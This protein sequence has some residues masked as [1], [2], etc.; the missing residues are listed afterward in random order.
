MNK[1]MIAVFF[2]LI[3]I[4]TAYALIRV[5]NESGTDIWLYFRTNRQDNRSYMVWVRQHGFISLPL[6]TF[7]VAATLADPNQKTEDI[8][9][10]GPAADEIPTIADSVSE[11]KVTVTSKAQ[12]FQRT[13]AYELI[14]PNAKELEAQYVKEHQAKVK[15][16]I[17]EAVAQ[18]PSGVA[19]IAAEYCSPEEEP[20][21]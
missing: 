19:G 14:I 2:A 16:R 10:M 7:A 21:K 9:K 20:K 13:F 11:V 8:S 1:R 17:Q 6:K 5:V 15:G 4:N 18:L 3:S 12:R